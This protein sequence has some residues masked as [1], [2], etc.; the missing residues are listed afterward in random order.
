MTAQLGSS[1]QEPGSERAKDPVD[2]EQPPGCGMFFSKDGRPGR[3]VATWTCVWWVRLAERHG[4]EP[5]AVGSIGSS[6]CGCG[7]DA[8]APDRLEGETIGW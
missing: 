7:E 4:S 2:N 5:S 8:A 6:M 3:P 1:T